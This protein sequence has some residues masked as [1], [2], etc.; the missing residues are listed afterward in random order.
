MRGK[1][2]KKRAEHLGVDWSIADLVMVDCRSNPVLE[3]GIFTHSQ[4]SRNKSYGEVLLDLRQVHQRQETP[5]PSLRADT[6][7]IL[8]SE[9]MNSP[10]MGMQRSGNI[11]FATKN[12]IM[13]SAEDMNDNS[14]TLKTNKVFVLLFWGNKYLGNGHVI[15]GGN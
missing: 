1:K 12:V 14:Q 7:N 13:N 2:T 3:D 4:Q 6:L 15:L 8:L 10:R 9:Q 5:F 11:R